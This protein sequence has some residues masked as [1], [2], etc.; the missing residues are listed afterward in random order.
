[1]EELGAEARA[2]EVFLGEREATERIG[3]D[4]VFQP[5]ERVPPSLF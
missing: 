4:H 5:E 2:F 1:M 3:Y